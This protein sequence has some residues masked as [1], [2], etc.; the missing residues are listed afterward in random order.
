MHRRFGRIS[1]FLRQFGLAEAEAEL[2]T[3]FFFIELK[4]SENVIAVIELTCVATL[5]TLSAT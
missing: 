5:E 2:A 3:N 4:I 1:Q